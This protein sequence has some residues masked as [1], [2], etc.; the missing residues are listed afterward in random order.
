MRTTNPPAYVLGGHQAGLA[1]VRSLGRA[2]VPVVAILSSTGDLAWHSRYP[3]DR[4]IGPDPADQT[5]EYADFLI[6]LR[7]RHG[8]GVIIPTTDESLEA[9]AAHRTELEAAHIVACP[10]SWSAG[11]FLDKR[12]TSEIA[13][14]V[15]VPAP[16]TACPQ[17]EA[18]LAS[19][20]EGLRF[21]CLVKPRESYRYTRAFGTKMTRVENADE[22][23]EAWR[24]AQALDIGTLIQEI[25]PGP[26]TCG[27]NYNVY[28]ID[29]EPVV[30]F[31]SR[32]LRLA[33][34]NYGYPAVVRTERVPEVLEAGR[35]IVRGMGIEG[36][37][38]AEFKLDERD[39]E[40]KLM[41]VNGRPNMSGA[42]AVHCGVDFPLMTYRHLV[43]GVTP[44]Q[45]PWR[46]GI[47]WIDKAD[48]LVLA[49]RWKTGQSSFPQGLAPYFSR[50][51]FS[52]FDVR[53]PAPSLVRLR[54]VG[55]V[56]QALGKHS[57]LARQ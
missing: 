4:E 44:R 57:P 18:E 14:D 46:E 26:E 38:N 35:R 22:L 17:S 32:K 24:A 6:A 16:G 56:S 25:I 8:P 31:T 21:P 20:L 55:R 34:P 45:T 41:E 13:A 10:S 37:A 39:G 42:L 49:E 27:V 19:A 36:F 1:V 15:D 33:P 30:E 50:H 23:R 47:H 7:E 3:Q 29:G 40:Y 5:R 11:V 28:M 9:V 52:G 51:I 2:G 12:A 48:R 53:D 43:H 54:G